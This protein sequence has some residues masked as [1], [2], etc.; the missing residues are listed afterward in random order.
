V[1]AG[2]VA[3]YGASGILV[4]RIHG[5]AARIPRHKIP[6]RA[7]YQR[8][9][10]AVPAFAAVRAVKAGGFVEGHDGIVFVKHDKLS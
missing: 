7:L 3:Q 10:R 2:I 8:A 1:H 4:A 5:K 6:C 9:F